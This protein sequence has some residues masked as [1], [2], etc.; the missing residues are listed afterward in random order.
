VAVM[1]EGFVGHHRPEV[2]AADTDVNDVAYALASVALPGA[3]PDPAG[4]V[5]H[6]VEH[7]VDLGH[8]ILAV[9]DESCS[10]RRTQSHVQDGSVF[11]DV[12]LFTPEHGVDARSQARF[13]RQLKKQL[14]SFVGD[15]ILR[16]IEEDAR[17]CGR[18]TLA[19]LG[20]IREELPEMQIPDLP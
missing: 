11:R 12:D 17:S 1:L 20:I 4:K 10:F 5:R 18:H 13:L 9:Y 7:G 15:A 3:A 16:V 19:A 14:Q 8:Y 6:L 2:G